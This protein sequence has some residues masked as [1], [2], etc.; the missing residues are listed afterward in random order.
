M[1]TKFKL[2][3]FAFSCFCT[4]TNG[5]VKRVLLEEFSTAQCGFC[6][7]GDIILNSILQKYPH[8]IAFTHH[9]GFGT[10]SMTIPESNTIAY[11]F[12]EFAPGGVIDRGNYKIPV[13]TLGNYIAV[14]RQKW[15]SICGV[16]LQNAPVADLD[17]K[18]TI[19]P[20]GN[21]FDC[22]VSVIFYS[23]PNPGDLRLN[24]AMDEDSVMKL[25][26]GYDQ[27]SYFN[28]DPTHPTLY[29]TGDTIK[30]YVHNHVLR[31]MP[32]GAW[33]L[34]GVFPQNPQLG[35]AYTYTFK[36]IPLKNTWNKN[37][38]NVVAFVGYYNDSA[39]QR[40]VLNTNQ[41]K[42]TDASDI[43]L[44]IAENG[45]NNKAPQF[46]VFPNPSNGS[47]QI[48]VDFPASTHAGFE[49]LD[50]KSHSVYASPAANYIT[51][52]HIINFNIPAAANGMYILRMTTDKGVY[53][54]KIS[55][56]Q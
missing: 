18:N 16:E 42:L 22:T 2:L 27:K 32:S 31:A 48:I 37:N 12:T 53:F 24:I 21:S 46:T 1:K 33:G 9:A 51:G 39:N 35:K 55:V 10:D 41:K 52:A 25:G 30:G 15:D 47:G 20:D 17:M 23:A 4:V 45:A 6:P 3:I 26:F 40:P 29:H 14:S 19:S 11:Y 13:Y 50:M 28:D 44:G 38:M 36:N 34:A 7:D 8:V 49:I 43:S 5:Q 56:M 54:D